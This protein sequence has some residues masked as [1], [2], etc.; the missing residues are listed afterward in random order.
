MDDISLLGMAG[1]FITILIIY[2]LT[3]MGDMVGGYLKDTFISPRKKKL[4]K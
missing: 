3:P 1:V 4:K 2:G